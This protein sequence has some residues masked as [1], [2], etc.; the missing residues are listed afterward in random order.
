MLRRTLSSPWGSLELLATDGQLQAIVFSD[1]VDLAAELASTRLAAG[2]VASAARRPAAQDLWVLDQAE[3]QLEE[4]A[5]GRRQ[6]F[7]L[8]LLPR[9]TEFQRTI[10][11]ALAKRVAFGTST[12]YGQL[13]ALAGR[14]R[15]VRAVGN[16][17]GRNPW[18]IVVPCHRVLASGACLGGFSS[19]L[20]RKRG[21]LRHERIDWREP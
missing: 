16:A 2:S 5:A 15:A 17:V 18:V 11:D 13:A 6:H 1:A 3:Q 19:G 9:G 20:E 12:S 4:Y 21:L 14:P 10:W 7:E 8:P